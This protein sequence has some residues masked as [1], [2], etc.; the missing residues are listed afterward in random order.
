MPPGPPTLNATTII[1][2]C[3]S[4]TA[5]VFRTA[6]STLVCTWKRLKTGTCESTAQLRNSATTWKLAAAY[7]SRHTAAKRKGALV[8]A[9]ALG[10]ARARPPLWKEADAASHRGEARNSPT[11]QPRTGLAMRLL[12]V[13]RRGVRI[14]S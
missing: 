5:L 14:E 7:R 6:R 13:L 2:A 11:R 1:L 3:T 10:S 12:E 4:E 9:D 8:L